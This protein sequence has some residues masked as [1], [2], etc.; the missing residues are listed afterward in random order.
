MLIVLSSSVLSAGDDKKREVLKV[1][2]D[3]NYLPFSHK[4]KSGYENKIAELIGKELN[5]PVVYTWFPQRMGFIR[6]T[7]KKKDDASGE[8]RCDLVIGVPKEFDFAKATIPYMRTTYALVT[9][10]DGKLK[11]LKKGNDFVTLAPEKLQG[12]KVGITERSPGALWLSKYG[13]YQ[14]MSP[15]IAQS[16]DPDEF[17]NEPMFKDLIDG[18][19]DAA[20]VWGPTAAYFSKLNSEKIKVLPLNTIPGVRFDFSISAAVRYGNDKWENQIETI[21]TKNVDNINGILNDAGIPLLENKFT[22]EKDDD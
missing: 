1:C 6:N 9:L 2:A 5:L 16:G 17:P 14:Q 13:L 20:I 8:Y 3:P 15:Y 19:I 21:L 10:K 12:I 11:E 4:D 22:P 18:N 7:L